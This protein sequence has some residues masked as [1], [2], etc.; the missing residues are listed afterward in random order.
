MKV[1][2]LAISIPL[3]KLD[4]SIKGTPHPMHSSILYDIILGQWLCE[5]RV[6]FT[7]C[8]YMQTQSV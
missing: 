2:G 7:Q 6:L 3:S 1:A 4:T 5:V 8:P